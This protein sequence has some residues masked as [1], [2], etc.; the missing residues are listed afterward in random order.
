M[1]Y[2]EIFLSLDSVYQY[3]TGCPKKCSFCQTWWRPLVNTSL[4]SQFRENVSTFNF[5]A[6]A[7]S[8]WVNMILPQPSYL[9]KN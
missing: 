6:N 2:S 1:S 5:L 4:I 8:G 7:L 9:K 3:Y